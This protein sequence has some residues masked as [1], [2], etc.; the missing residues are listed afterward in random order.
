MSTEVTVDPFESQRDEYTIYHFVLDVSAGAVRRK[1]QFGYA[2][3]GLLTHVIYFDHDSDG[4]ID[5]KMMN[6]YAKSIPGLE[7]AADWLI[8]PEHSQSV[9]D[10]FRLNVDSAEKL[11]M[12]AVSSSTNNTVGLL[13][14]WLN[15]SSEDLAE[16]IED[17]IE[18]D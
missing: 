13:W 2:Y 17:A 18:F 7:M 9:Y 5:T 4:V 8:D 1:L 12:D 6:Q 11:T 3:S 14:E 15:E 16:W 10:A